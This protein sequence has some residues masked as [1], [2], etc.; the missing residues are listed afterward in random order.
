MKEKDRISIAKSMPKVKRGFNEV[1]KEQVLTE[2]NFWRSERWSV[3]I[4]N[5][6]YTL[7]KAIAYI[8]NNVSSNRRF[9]VAY[10]KRTL[11]WWVGDWKYYM[12]AYKRNNQLF[13]RVFRINT[14]ITIIN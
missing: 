4:N 2:L 14:Y 9:Y 7:K 10:N 12:S 5:K 13:S 1:T 8:S 3:F 6:R 11:P